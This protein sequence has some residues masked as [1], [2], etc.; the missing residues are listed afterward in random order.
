MEYE[1]PKDRRRLRHPW[2]PTI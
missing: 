1:F 2:Q